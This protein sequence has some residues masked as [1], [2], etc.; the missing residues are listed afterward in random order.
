[1]CRKNSKKWT[2]KPRFFFFFLGGG[3]CLPTT[4]PLTPL[5]AQCNVDTSSSHTKNITHIQHF[6]P[7]TPRTLNHIFSKKTHKNYIFQ[8]LSKLSTCSNLSNPLHHH[9]LFIFIKFPYPLPQVSSTT[10]IIIHQPPLSIF[11]WEKLK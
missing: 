2:G 1:M 7:M 8:E 9:F 11:F 10:L 6:V 5:R 4:P 3:C